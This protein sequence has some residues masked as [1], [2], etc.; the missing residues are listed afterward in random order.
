MRAKLA[1][2]NHCAVPF[3]GRALVYL[4]WCVYTIAL[5]WFITFCN[6]MYIV[7]CTLFT[8][9]I[10]HC[11]PYIVHCRL[12]IVDCTLYIVHCTLCTMYNEQCTMYNVQCTQ[13]TMNNVQ[14]TY[15]Y[16]KL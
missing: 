7:H 10:V 9:Y 2:L 6:R 16:E 1:D 4:S 13:R 14:C 15:G 8:F 5:S 11:T 12:Y 3:L